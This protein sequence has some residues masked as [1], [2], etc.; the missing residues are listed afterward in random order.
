MFQT[1]QVHL[2]SLMF[3]SLEKM[4]KRW[5]LSGD[6][7]NYSLVKD[8]KFSGFNLLPDI[9]KWLYDV[10]VRPVISSCGCYTKKYFSFFRLSFT[11][12]YPEGKVI[13]KK[14]NLL[15]EEN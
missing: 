11:V 1:T 3:K 2:L 4:R 9:H 10:L 6:T 7:L 12:S 5:N 8:P 13:Y 15:V 14:Y